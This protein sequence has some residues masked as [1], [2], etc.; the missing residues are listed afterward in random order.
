MKWIQ[1]FRREKN[2]TPRTIYMRLVRFVWE[3]RG[4]FAENKLVKV[5]L[6]KI[7]KCLINV[8]LLRIIMDSRTPYSLFW[9]ISSL[10][11]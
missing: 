4:V 7:D 11:I 1:D 2:D 5:F 8:V 10:P 9:E 6:S 3:S